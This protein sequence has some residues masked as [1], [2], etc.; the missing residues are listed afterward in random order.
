MYKVKISK[1][2]ETNSNKAKSVLPSTR[3]KV[4]SSFRRPSN[5]DSPFKNSVLSNT[6][7][8]FEKVEVFV[9]TNK[10]TY[11]A[12]KNVVS[13]KKV[14]TDVDVKNALKVKDVSCV[15]CAKNVLILC[16]DKCLMN[17]KL[18]VHS[19]VRRALF[20]TP[21]IAKYTCEDTTPVVSKTRFS[22]KTTQSKSIDTI[23]VVSKTKIAAITPLS[24]K[25]KVSN[26]FKT[27]TEILREIS[28]SK[29]MKNKI[30]TSRIFRRSSFLSYPGEVFTGPFLAVLDFR[31]Q[32]QDLLITISELKA[33]L[34]NV[35]KG[36]RAIS[37]VRRPSNRDSSFKDNFLSITKNSLKKVDVS[38][39][40]NKKSDVASKNV[41]SNK[42]IVTNDGIKNA[43]IA[44]NVLCICC[45]KNVHI[46]CHDN[47]LAKYKLNVHTK[48]RRV[49]FTTS[50]IV[51][52]KL[53][54]PTLV[55][56]K[57]RF[58]VKTVQS[59]SLDTT[60]VVSKTKI[61]AVAPLSAKHKVVQIVL[62]IVDSGCL[63]HMTGD[64]SLVKTFVEKFMGTV[65]F[66][67]DHFTAITGYGDYV[68]GNIT[69]CHVYYVKGLGHNL[70]SVGQFCD[71]DL[72]VAF[73]SK[74]CY[75]RNLEGKRSSDTSINSATQQVHNHEDSPSISSTVVKEHETPPI[76]TTFD[77]QTSPISLN[78]ADESYQED[79]ANFDGITVFVPYDAPIF[80]D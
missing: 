32:N 62:W 29:Y 46:L 51:K 24:A 60:P 80:E 54:G 77:E 15:S 63:K 55:V 13:N 33:K 31:A 12:Y 35:K 5:R 40:S 66:R 28:L 72:E 26:A 68:K 39:R 37:S 48:V 56:L 9:R 76:V 11:V 50:R 3:L 4:A 78:E 17:Y 19:K 21:R 20:T 25:N 73:R 44:N 6:K 65:R 53:E 23:P 2:Q 70:F 59:K 52:S 18:N 36:L 67:N 38:D 57:T 75:V 43:L 45:A 64:R 47:C 71:G 41:D 34:K 7:K 79:S 14:V 8:S 1:K 30:Q 16:H 74:T 42:N 69:V 61:A 10:K 22:V 58:S 27:I 49:L